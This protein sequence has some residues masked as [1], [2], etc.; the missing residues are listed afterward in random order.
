MYSEELLT[1]VG[2][3][4]ILS[5]VVLLDFQRCCLLSLSVYCVR[6]LQ[7]CSVRVLTVYRT[8]IGRVLYTCIY[9]V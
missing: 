1:H 9:C 6:V 7:L 2:G 3:E 5:A 4:A 8:Y